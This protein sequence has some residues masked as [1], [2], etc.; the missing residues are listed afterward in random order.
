MATPFAALTALC[1]SGGFPIQYGIGIGVTF[2]PLRDKPFW[3]DSTA[4]AVDR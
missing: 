1:Q 4:S 3:D 2:C